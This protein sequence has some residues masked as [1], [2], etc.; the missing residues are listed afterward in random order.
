MKE[1]VFLVAINH[2]K[3]G[4][5]AVFSLRIISNACLKENIM[6]KIP[7]CLLLFVSFGWIAYDMVHQECAFKAQK[8]CKFMCLEGMILHISESCGLLRLVLIVL[9]SLTLL[10]YT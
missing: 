3:D 10:E 9:M 4:F 8:S 2:G 6:K 5:C 7:Q 1:I